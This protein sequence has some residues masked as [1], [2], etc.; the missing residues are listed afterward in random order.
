M[1]SGL[2][3]PCAEEAPE[4]RDRWAYVLMTEELRRVVA[5]VKKDAPELFRRMVFNALISSAQPRRH[6]KRT[7]V[8]SLACLR[9]L[10]DSRAILDSAL[11]CT[12]VRMTFCLG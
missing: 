10:G 4:S 11:A 8:E 2:T 9:P 3:P 12:T 1:I 5:E 6:R 7:R